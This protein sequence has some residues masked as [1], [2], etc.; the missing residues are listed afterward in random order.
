MYFEQIKA[1]LVNITDFS[2][3]LKKILP[4]PLNISEHWRKKKTKQNKTQV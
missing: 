4:T 1:G 3:T 2:K